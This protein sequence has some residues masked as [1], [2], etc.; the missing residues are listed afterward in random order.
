MKMIEDIR[1][2]NMRRLATELGG[3]TQLADRLK[4]SESQISQWINRSTNYG[5]GKP[6]GMRSGTARWI[7]SQLNKP[8]GWLD[9]SHGTDIVHSDDAANIPARIESP[10]TPFVIQWPFKNLRIERVAALPIAEI[11]LLEGMLLGAITTI[12]ARLNKPPLRKLR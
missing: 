6:R 4:R 3:N 10:V 1:A 9:I 2:E 11:E 12:E 8:H 5:T 7:E